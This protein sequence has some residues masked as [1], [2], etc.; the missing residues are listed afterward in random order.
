MEAKNGLENYAYNMRNT[1]RDEKAASKMDPADKATIEKA[2]ED[3]IH[4]WVHW[5]RGPECVF[6]CVV[7]VVCVCLGW[8]GMCGRG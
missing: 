7:V 5:C 6:M 2:V 1:I 4:W 3:A 8:G